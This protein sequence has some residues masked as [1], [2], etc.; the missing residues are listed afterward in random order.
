ML[1]E[2]TVE[3][4][5]Q[6]ILG[7]HQLFVELPMDAKKLCSQADAMELQIDVENLAVPYQTKVA[8]KS[9]CQL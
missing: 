8:L 7:N 5:L 2:K 3:L 4:K 1:A 6:R 9:G